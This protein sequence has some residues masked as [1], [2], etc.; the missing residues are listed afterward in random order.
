MK[1]LRIELR[2]AILF[3]LITAIWMFIEHSFLGWHDKYIGS[4]FQNHFIVLII[5]FFVMYY[6]ALKEKRKYD[7]NG[8]I[9]WKQAFVSGMLISIFIAILSPLI[10]YFNYN[11]ISPHYFDNMIAYQTQ[12][13][14]YPMSQE[15]AEQIF[16]MKSFI[17][18][19]V[20]T[21]F[22]FGIFISAIV[23]LL[24]RTD[25]KKKK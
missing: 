14:S 8:K 5:L 21:S 19:G 4:Q 3:S 18:Q 24:I 20:F 22:S 1:N 10:E 25:K 9:T 2:W 7:Y 15:D 23:A 16:N 13:E 6:Y 12:K 17:F 11:Y